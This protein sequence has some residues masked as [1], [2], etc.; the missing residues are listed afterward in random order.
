M[1]PLTAAAIL[2]LTLTEHLNPIQ[3][4]LRSHRTHKTA[5]HVQVE[6]ASSLNDNLGTAD[7]LRVAH[8]KGWINSDFAVIPCDIVTNL[9]GAKLAEMWMVTQASF[10]S[11]LGRRARKHKFAMDAE[12]G[13]RGGLAVWY[14]TM[15]EG[16]IKGQETDFVAAAPLTRPSTIGNEFPD[17]DVGVLLTTAPTQALKGL[18]QLPIRHGMMKRHPDVKLYTTFRDAGIYFFPYWVLKFIE[19][20]PKLNSVREDVLPWIAKSRWQN[21]RLAKKLGLEQ[22]LNGEPGANTEM[23]SF[24]DAQQAYDVGSMSTARTRRPEDARETF[25]R[26][27][28]PPIVAYLPTEQSLFV[29]RVDTVHLY[30]FTSLHLAK[31]D[32]TLP[33]TQVKI[34]P[35]AHIGEKAI[36]TQI[37]CLIAEKVSIGERCVIKKS[38]LGTGVSIGRG[39]RIMGCVLMD[40]ASVAEN[41]KLEG[42]T[43]GRKANIGAK[44]NLKDCEVADGYMVEDGGKFFFFFWLEI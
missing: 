15:G 20:N 41:A 8:G 38:V 33:A 27:D 36:V 19:K 3:S 28:V 21:T 44:V 10:D 4:F 14:Q 26:E 35:T 30:L 22:I 6:A 43:I 17:G 12:D 40:G 25:K 39:A 32:P 2:V 42:C 11:D 5:I 7:V 13:R 24:E 18:N 37:D 34:D 23:E 29:R 16:A 9:D 31:S 1:T